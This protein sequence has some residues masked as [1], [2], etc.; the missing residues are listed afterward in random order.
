VL[1]TAEPKILPALTGFD[2]MKTLSATNSLWQIENVNVVRL[3]LL[4]MRAA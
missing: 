4:L 2:E 3:T 1:L